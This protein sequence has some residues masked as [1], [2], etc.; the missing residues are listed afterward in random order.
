MNMLTEHKENFILNLPKYSFS[1][2]KDTMF[3]R[4]N[5][6]KQTKSYFHKACGNKTI[7][8]YEENS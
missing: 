3:S 7:A 5:Q 6:S 1:E 4:I 8:G 2:R